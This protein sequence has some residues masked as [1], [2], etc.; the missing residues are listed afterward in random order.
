MKP[1]F[2]FLLALLA[3]LTP[4]THGQGAAADYRADVSRSTVRFKAVVNQALIREVKGTLRRF[5][6]DGRIDSGS[7]EVSRGRVV[8]QMDSVTSDTFGVSD[9]LLRDKLK[10]AQYPTSTIDVTAVR[11]GPA[12]DQYDVDVD[13]K[14]QDKDLKGTVRVKTVR[15]PDHLRLLG[16]YV[17]PKDAQGRWGE[18]EF[19]L[20]LEAR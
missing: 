3:S 18:I 13:V 17:M 2:A 5:S 19:S 15:F 10:T 6:F 11:R 20:R 9:S 16:T 12:A 7:P 14:A 1:F 4:V 8:I